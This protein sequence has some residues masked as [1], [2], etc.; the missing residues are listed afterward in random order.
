MLFYSQIQ[1]IC[2]LVCA[3][4]LLQSQDF[5]KVERRFTCISRCFG[6]LFQQAVQNRIDDVKTFTGYDCDRGDIGMFISTRRGTCT[7]FSIDD[8]YEFD[9]ALQLLLAKARSRDASRF[10][11]LVAGLYG[12]GASPVR[13]AVPATELKQSSMYELHGQHTLTSYIYL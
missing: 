10:T 13:P 11:L 3:A 12:P 9:E 4:D 5:A 7:D 1:K 8:S 2:M 6:P